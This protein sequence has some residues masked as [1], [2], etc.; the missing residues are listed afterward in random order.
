MPCWDLLRWHALKTAMDGLT[1]ALED[2][3]DEASPPYLKDVFSPRM[4]TVFREAFA[5][6]FFGA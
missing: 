1:E 2:D 6:F 4:E 3:I 5:D